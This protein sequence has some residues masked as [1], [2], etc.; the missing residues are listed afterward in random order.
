MLPPPFEYLKYRK[1][2]VARTR[3]SH[4]SRSPP[5]ISV[6]VV[7]AE[8]LPPK[9]KGGLAGYVTA[10]RLR[11]HVS[12]R[13]PYGETGRRW[14][15]QRGREG[16]ETRRWSPS[17]ST[18]GRRYWQRIRPQPQTCRIDQT[19]QTTRFRPEAPA[20]APRTRTRMAAGV[21]AARFSGQRRC[22]LSTRQRRAYRRH[23]CS[24]QHQW[25]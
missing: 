12:H 18:L 21:P 17:G 4:H 5:G 19:L 13:P 10:S 8:I 3:T 24:D 15:P 2:P 22:C 14:W 23:R 7:A 16:L 11:E 6:P 20:P 1:V 9:T 25:R